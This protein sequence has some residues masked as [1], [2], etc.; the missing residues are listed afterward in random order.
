[1]KK[2][3]LLTIL[4][5]GIVANA[6]AQDKKVSFGIR[7][8]V[9]ISSLSYSTSAED[10][11]APDL[12]SKTGFNVGVI[13]DW[14][15]AGNFYVQPGIY[16]TTRGAKSEMFDAEYEASDKLEVNMNYLQIPILASYRFPVS[17]SIKIDIN[18]GPYFSYGMGGKFK[19]EWSYS[20][21]TEKIEGKVFDKSSEDK[22]GGDLK[23]FDAGLRFGAGVQIQNFYIG[24][25]YDLGLSNI[26]DGGSEYSTW[27]KNDKLKNG[28]VAVM[29]GYNF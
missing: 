6:S 24:V 11:Y 23:R 16:F 3:F 15:V 17:N 28:C 14:N 27:R 2:L 10:D 9:N 21:E 12:K 1:M 25:N 13:A 4:V 8:G 29:V 26:A 5:T 20:G 7:A 19:N 18:A 22:T